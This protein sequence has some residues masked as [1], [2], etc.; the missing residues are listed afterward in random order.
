VAAQRV[1][2]VEAVPRREVAAG[3]FDADAVDGGDAVGPALVVAEV[4]VERLLEMP[5]V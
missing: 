4:G 5:R 2:A 3:L 1:P